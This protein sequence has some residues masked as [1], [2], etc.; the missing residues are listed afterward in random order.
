MK[1]KKEKEKE[2]ASSNKILILEKEKQMLKITLDHLIKENESLKNQIED[3]KQTVQ[4]NKQQLKEYIDNIT[5]KDKVVE[6]MNN[7]IEQLMNRINIYDHFYNMK[8]KNEDNNLIKKDMEINDTSRINSEALPT[9]NSEINKNSIQNLSMNTKINMKSK[10]NP[11]LYDNTGVSTGVH[12]KNSKSCI[13]D[14]EDV[15]AI[16]KKD[17]KYK[18][19]LS[20]N[21]KSLENSL[22][23][24]ENEKEK[25][26]KIPNQKGLNYL[27]K[28]QLSNNTYSNQKD[29]K[30]K[31]KT[32]LNSSHIHIHIKE[33]KDKDKDKS[34]LKVKSE[35][36]QRQFEIISNQN[37]ILEELNNLKN[38]VRF[39]F[40]SAIIS[41]QKIKENILLHSQCYINEDI[42]DSNCNN[43]NENDKQNENENE[44]ID[45]LIRNQ[46]EKNLNKT[47]VNN[48]NINNETNTQYK[49]STQNIYSYNIKER[50]GNLIKINQFQN[51]LDSYDQSRNILLIID[52][53]E[54]CWE[55]VKRSDIDL[56]NIKIGETIKSVVLN[57]F[58]NE[59][60][61]NSKVINLNSKDEYYEDDKDNTCNS[62]LNIS[63]GND[64]LI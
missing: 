19:Q 62:I 7:T 21:I 1:S 34:I 11:P 12:I 32:S 53:D 52:A 8:N 59:L 60:L 20:Y 51:F 42:N 17:K 30:F 3:M 29:N 35:N 61:L 26:L 28:N 44:Y 40:D 38:D 64:S 58:Y 22:I 39:L 2:T 49:F 9:I 5:N 33:N 36:V 57:E 16:I 43:F 37:M 46:T 27:N 45:N 24:K 15:G 23:I 54:C 41:K 63:R 48:S 47:Y 25:I 56:S 4:L 50:T 6:K 14:T 10:S 18:D 31:Y 55:I 13:F